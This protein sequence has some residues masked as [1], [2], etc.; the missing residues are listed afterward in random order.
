MGLGEDRWAV[1]VLCPRTL[2]LGCNSADRLCSGNSRPASPSH[3][4]PAEPDAIRS[5]YHLPKVFDNV[6]SKFP[7]SLKL[8]RSRTTHTRCRNGRCT[9][10]DGSGCGCRFKTSVS[11]TNQ[12]CPTTKNTGHRSFHLA[13]HCF[14]PSILSH[15]INV[16]SLRWR[17]LVWTLGSLLPGVGPRWLVCG[18]GTKCPFLGGFRFLFFF[19]D[20]KNDQIILKTVDTPI[21][22]ALWISLPVIVLSSLVFLLITRRAHIHTVCLKALCPPR[23]CNTLTDGSPSSTLNDSAHNHWK[24]WNMSCELALRNT[25]LR[26]I[27]QAGHFP[28]DSSRCIT[29]AQG[30][31]RG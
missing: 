20:N 16:S 11:D 1:F 10:G 28:S 8:V 15:F 22:I 23:P 17:R 2:R 30:T 14:L 6:P 27:R 4:S 12:K 21:S 29:R 19:L 18:K 5:V 25:H 31:T 3:L 24:I 26:L 13:L 9:A 7:I